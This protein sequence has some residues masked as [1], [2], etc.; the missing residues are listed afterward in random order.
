M[1]RR[2]ANCVGHI[3][4]RNCLSKFVSE[5][6]IKGGIE[7]TG[8]R[9]TTCKQLLYDLKKKRC[10]CK[11]KKGVLFPT[12]WRTSCGRSYGPVV[13]KNTEYGMN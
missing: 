10:Y 5:G 3:L 4:R 2:K 1:K 11:L 6:K 12:L 13:R 8:R 7:V 9:E